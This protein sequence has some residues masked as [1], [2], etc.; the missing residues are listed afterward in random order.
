MPK[1][2]KSDKT[3]SRTMSI[4]P[5]AAF[6]CPVDV[7]KRLRPKVEIA[8]ALRRAYRSFRREPSSVARTRRYL[9]RRSRA[10]EAG[11]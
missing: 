11:R 7:P 6:I 4:M 8:Q 1:R 9:P 3:S 10:Y 2:V 5:T